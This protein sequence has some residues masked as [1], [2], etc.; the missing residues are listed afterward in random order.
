MC[1]QEA[2]DRAAV[3]ETAAV[4]ADRLRAMAAE[5]Q[6]R[7][8]QALQAAEAESEAQRLR[9][10]ELEQLCLRQLQEYETKMN[11]RYRRIEE[12]RHRKGPQFAADLNVA[13]D[14]FWDAVLACEVKV[15]EAQDACALYLSVY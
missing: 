3:A 2:G 4:E 1:L 8:Q 6:Q 13:S 7:L 5:E 14:E 12:L 15:V 10:T 9:A 11:T